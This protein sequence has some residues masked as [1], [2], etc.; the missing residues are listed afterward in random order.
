MPDHR[1]S[2][3]PQK[4]LTAADSA[5]KILSSAS[6]FVGTFGWLL[7]GRELLASQKRLQGGHGLLASPYSLILAIGLFLA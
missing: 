2:I 1:H 7:F 4:R 3:P 6:H 5:D